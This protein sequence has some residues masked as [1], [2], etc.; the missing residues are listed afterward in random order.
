MS[1]RII[2]SCIELEELQK[3]TYSASLEAV[4]TSK[5]QNGLILNKRYSLNEMSITEDPIVTPFY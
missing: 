1:T 4:F 2:V 3:H 5:I